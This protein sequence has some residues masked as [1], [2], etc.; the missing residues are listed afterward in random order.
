MNTPTARR[1]ERGAHWIGVLKAQIL[2][3][4][5]AVCLD[6]SSQVSTFYTKYKTALAPKL[7]REVSSSASASRNSVS[8]AVKGVLFFLALSSS[9]AARSSAFI[10]PEEALLNSTGSGGESETEEKN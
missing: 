6:L 1:R 5:Q 2:R 4:A 3:G 10:L 7:G 9:D 8:S